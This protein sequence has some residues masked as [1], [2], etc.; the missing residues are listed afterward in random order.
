MVGYYSTDNNSIYSNLVSNTTYC[1]VS[2]TTNVVNR[3]PTLN[4]LVSNVPVFRIYGDSN[5]YI[6]PIP[7]PVIND[8]ELCGKKSELSDINIEGET[9]ELCT[10]CRDSVIMVEDKTYSLLER[11][12]NFF[13]IF[14]RS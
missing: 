11:I 6:R 7:E 1:T 5:Q 8:C 10:L 3:G 14:R 9:L 13:N 2:S 12:T 4:H